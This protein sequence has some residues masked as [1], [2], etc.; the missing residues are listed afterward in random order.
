MKLFV[1][2]LAG[3]LIFFLLLIVGLNLYFTDDRLKNMILPQVNEALDREVRV[4][5][6]SMTFFRT[7]PRFGL[8]LN[9]FMLPDDYGDP[10]AEFESLIAGVR[11][12]P[13]FRDEISI[14]RLEV[15]KPNIYYK[16]YADSTTNIDFLLDDEAEVEEAE[17]GYTIQIPMFVIREAGIFYSDETS[18]TRVDMEGLDADIGLSFADLIESSVDA[19]LRSLSASHNGTQYVSNLT[20][21]LQQK[22][23][24]D[25]AGELLTLTEG[26][27]SIRGLALNLSGSVGQWSSDAPELDLQFSSTSDNFGELLGLAPP[28]FDEYLQGLETSGSLTLEGIV[29]GSLVEGRLPLFDLTAEVTD[30]F[31]KNPDLQE[32]IRDINF[33]LHAGNE[34]ISLNRLTAE[35]AGN[36]IE[37]S[38]NLDR[39]FDEDA[40]F[41]FRV[42]G[43]IDL[44]TISQFY[45][46]GQ[47]GV[48]TLTG[49]LAIDADA[50]G[51]LQNPEAANFNGTM[52]LRN[53]V[54]KY[55]DVPRPI[56]HIEAEITAN[57][58]RITINTASFRAVNNRFSM[59]GSVTEPLAGMPSFDIDADLDFDLATI[60]DFY[61]ID[62]DTLTLRGQFKA[63]AKLR[64]QADQV[65]R[66]LQESNIE[67]RNGYIDHRL[68][69]KPLEDI[70]FIATT[71]NT[72]L[73]ISEARFR[74]GE[75]SLSMRG[76]V[77][78]FMDEDPLFDLTIDGN[79]TLAD[80][81]TYYSLEP[82]ISELTGLAVMNL[83]AKGPAGVPTEIALNGSLRLENVNARG[84]SLS[85]PV[86]GLRGELTVRPDAMTL[87]SFFMKYGSSDFSLQGR[88]QNY[89]GFLQEHETEA[90]MPAISGT[91][92]SQ[93]LNLDEMF[94]WDE[95]ADDEP[96]PI[97]LPKMT[98]TV[99]AQIDTL[100]L[101][102]VPIYNIS[103]RGHTNPERIVIDEATAEMF[104][105]TANGRLVWN[106][107][108]PDY[109]NITFVGQL[110]DLQA[111]AF[112]REFPILGKNSRFE[113]HVSGGFSANVDYYTEL[114]EYIDPDIT[115]TVAGGSFGMSR[116]R[117]RGHPVQERLADWLRANELRSLAL[118]EW[119]ATFTIDESVLTLRDFRLTSESIGIELSGTQHLVSDE[120]DFTAQLLLPSRFRSGIASV[121]SSRAVDAMTRED[122]IIV[123]PIRIT[124]TMGS[125]Q[126]SPRQS[127]IEDL[128]RDT[129]RDVLRRLFDRN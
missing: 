94:D 40:P 89:L 98:S 75:N 128:L 99:N 38:G 21:S 25:M 73:N 83:N 123:V 26:T 45:P 16:V 86:T 4:D 78:H 115:K 95:E 124:G 77:D 71:R 68:V 34:N 17:T 54:F 42:K 111:N 120:I 118:D 91:Y 59:S 76:T 90:T 72:R 97:E 102:G 24:I 66:A 60:K 107:P 6:M 117:L 33:S 125:P 49:L 37:A 27:F 129:G 62:E 81:S 53:G 74:T 5:R 47:A 80:V 28:E 3:I 12:F 55:I 119:V 44:E 82:W 19:R 64:G 65:A 105:G 88:L 116:A 22:S 69:G 113:Q 112:F 7:F 18:D 96:I 100:M 126:I 1:K 10:V 84:D 32:P 35:A 106:V 48:E 104:N 109:T 20:L 39:P 8:E 87:E 63:G 114:D 92:H 58:N 23:V 51:N 61:P 121:I 43:D 31:L 13:L 30:G 122:G 29:A 110:N 9:G 85:L 79:A 14:S 36:R 67:L 108:Q 15:V 57:Q 93:M 56:E 46:I 52:T 2:I 11:L 70:T 103:G 127:I 41:S 50:A 101:F